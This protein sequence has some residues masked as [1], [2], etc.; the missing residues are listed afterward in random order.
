MSTASTIS[1]RKL[2]ANRAN[3]SKSTG[4][5]S[6]AGKQASSSNAI[7]HGLFAKHIILVGEDQNHFHTLKKGFL[8]RRN[9]RDVLELS[10]VDKI[11]SIHWKM[12]RLRQAELEFMQQAYAKHCDAKDD[13][14]AMKQQSLDQKL[15]RAERFLKRAKTENAAAWEEEI[16]T[17][18][19]QIEESKH[20]AEPAP[21]AGRYL[22]NAMSGKDVSLPERYRKY[23]VQLEN[24]LHRYMKE[25]RILQSENPSEEPNEF[26]KCVMDEVD[27]ETEN[28]PTEA[29]DEA[30]A[31]EPEAI[32]TEPAKTNPPMENRPAGPG[33]DKGTIVTE[34]GVFSEG[35]VELESLGNTDRR[36]TD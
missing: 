20:P 13:E 33:D 6:E 12:H 27:T 14:Q 21:R 3:A 1:D 15:R 28:E 31:D 9:P 26:A 23:E 35:F 17:L 16:R 30:T 5:R 32:E 29:H 10:L 7:Q 19:Q 24:S 11:V 2:A 25:Y 8:L 18:T 36:D 4:P 22:M 34:S